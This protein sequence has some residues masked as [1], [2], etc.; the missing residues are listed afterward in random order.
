M[1]FLFILCLNYEILLIL[2]YVLKVGQKAFHGMTN[3]NRI[4]S[5][6]FDAAYN[7]NENLLVCA[8]TGAGKTNVALLTIIHQIKQH[9]RNNEIHKN[10]F[11]VNNF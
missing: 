7:T 8:P 10:E 4:Q 3:L 2:I 6:V 1:R 9:I 5:V 11:K